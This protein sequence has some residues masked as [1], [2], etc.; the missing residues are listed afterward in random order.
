MKNTYV[1]CFSD[2][3]TWEVV[4][5]AVLIYE[6]SSSDLDKLTVGDAHP[7]NLDRKPLRLAD[8]LREQE[9]HDNP[10]EDF[11]NANG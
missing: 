1:V 6:V 11:P 3:S 7:H 5:E 10:E 2:G 9:K 8:L 4:G